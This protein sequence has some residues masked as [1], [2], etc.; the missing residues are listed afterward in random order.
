MSQLSE[1]RYTINMFQARMKKY[2]RGIG[3]VEII[4]GVAIITLSLI[5]VVVSFN[6][7]F[8]AGIENTKKIQATYLAEE[9]IEVMRFLRDSSWTLNIVPLSTTTTYH[10]FF[11]GLYWETTTTPL[12]IDETFERTI[13]LSDVYRRDSD[14][15]IVPATSTLP[16]TADPAIRLITI[17]LAWPTDIGSTTATTTFEMQTYIADIF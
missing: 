4:V 3:V 6:L 17:G 10:L 9:G 8:K 15:D 7:H 5:G 14:S 13:T 11:N 12:Y 1:I 2:T 16:K